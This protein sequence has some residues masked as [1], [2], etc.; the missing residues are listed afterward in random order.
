VPRFEGFILLEKAEIGLVDAE[1][2]AIMKRMYLFDRRSVMVHRHVFDFWWNVLWFGFE[3]LGGWGLL[4]LNPGKMSAKYANLPDIVRT[5]SRIYG[6][7][8]TYQLSGYCARCVRN[9]G[10]YRSCRPSGPSPLTNQY[11]Y[12]SP[13]LDA[14]HTHS[15]TGRIVRRRSGSSGPKT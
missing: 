6:T 2:L 10:H 1:Q 11:I 3:S 7:T 4:V 13:V 14:H 15:I 8:L 9:R 5:S 12:M